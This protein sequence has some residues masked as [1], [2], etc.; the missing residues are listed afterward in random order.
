M[1]EIYD[2]VTALARAISAARRRI[3]G[4]T[5][6]L[7]GLLYLALLGV[8]R[9]ATRIQQQKDALEREVAERTRVHRESQAALAEAQRA[10]R[11]A[12]EARAAADRAS[13]AKSIFLATMSHEIRTPLNGVIGMTEVL[14]ADPLT[15]TQRK[16]LQ[17]VHHSALS[18]LRLLSDLLDFSRL[19]ADAVQLHSAP[20]SLRGVLDD[21]LAGMQPRARQRGL[22]LELRI[23]PDVPEHIAADEARV[24]QVVGNLLTNALKFTH[25]GNVTLEV[26]RD[27]ASADRLVFR[28]RDTGIGIAANHLD[29]IF[30][31]FEQVDG[32][33]TR[34]H[35]GAGLGLSIC[36]RLVELMD[37]QIGVQSRE[38][39]GSTFWFTMRF[40]PAAALAAAED[41]DLGQTLD[42]DVL[43]VKDDAVNEI[44]A[45][46]M[47]T[48]MGCAVTVASGGEEALDKLEHRTFDAVL[49]DLH[50][51]GIDGIETTR[52]IRARETL[53][54]ARRMPIVALTADA[55]PQTRARCV[56]AGMD[57]VLAKPFTFASLHAALQPLLGA[58]AA[59]NRAATATDS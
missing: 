14:L 59:I 23:D 12:E 31:P 22:A 10:R 57:D 5:V 6:A 25:V 38:G 33:N 40:Q 50:M 27:P 19:E 48:L 24:R 26:A 52:R 30:R 44:V 21:L 45:R 43:V 8:V 16:Q 32:T 49:M 9:R 18:L 13:H 56:A 36:R 4:P 11:D 3:V 58:T 28:V 20:F 17:V 7:M 35:G 54:A 46:E 55:F 15:E 39:Q 42:A 53:T 47:L 29:R 1:V 2:D 51:A 41:A 37:G 34:R